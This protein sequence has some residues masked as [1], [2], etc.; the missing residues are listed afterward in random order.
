M[1]GPGARASTL[2][3]ILVTVCV[4]VAARVLTAGDTD[5]ALHD[6]LAP[7]LLGVTHAR[8][9]THEVPT[10]QVTAL[11]ERRAIRAVV[12]RVADGVVAVL[13]VGPGEVERQ[14]PLSQLP[15]DTHEGDW[16]I[17]HDGTTR[18]GEGDEARDRSLYELD[19]ETTAAATARLREKLAALRARGCA[20][21]CP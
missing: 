5:L 19:P 3:V 9:E 12:D 14:V 7:R 10:S 4:L 6:F 20:V 15:Q 18:D 11:D 8:P 17:V 2:K 16:L 13:L 1:Q 21:T